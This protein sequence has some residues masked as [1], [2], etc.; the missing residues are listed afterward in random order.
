MISF[1]L[2][3]IIILSNLILSCNLHQH[4]EAAGYCSSGWLQDFGISGVLDLPVLRIELFGLLIFRV[5]HDGVLEHDLTVTTGIKAAQEATEEREAQVDPDM[6]V[7][8]FVAG[9]MVITKWAK[10]R[11]LSRLTTYG[12]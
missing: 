12:S 11:R 7:E 8:H 6:V 10:T 5:L 4:C 2:T 3:G 9:H 1:D